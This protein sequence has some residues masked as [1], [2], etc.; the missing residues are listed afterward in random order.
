MECPSHGVCRMPGV[1]ESIQRLVDVLSAH[2]TVQSLL[3]EIVV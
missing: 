3:F 1:P 2:D